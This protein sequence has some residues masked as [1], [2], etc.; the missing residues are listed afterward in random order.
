MV[1]VEKEKIDA[2]SYE[3][4]I[5]NVFAPIYPV[6]AENIIKKTGICRGIC[7]DVGAGTGHLGITLSKMTE[8]K[9]ILL[10]K[11]YD[12]LL[13]A[14]RNIVYENL[15]DRVI[16]LMGDVHN[17]PLSDNTIDLV[18]SRGSMVYWRDKERAFKEILRVMSV[19]GSAYI[20]GGFGNIELGKKINIKMREIDINWD[21]NIR[22]KI[23]KTDIDY[24]EILKK[25]KVKNYEIIKDDANMWVNFVKGD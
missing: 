15:D 10:D 25:L 16:S 7:L 22:N 8:L 4:T 9:V 11:S 2:A 21:K 20:G 23:E 19:G 5:K 6:I 14:D 17:I 3:N 13:I 18:I 12:M 1:N 24:G